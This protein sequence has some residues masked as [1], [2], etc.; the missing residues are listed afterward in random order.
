M[1]TPVGIPF[2]GE[3]W[4]FRA[5]RTRAPLRSL[6]RR[7]KPL[8]SSF[9]TTHGAPMRLERT[10]S[11]IRRSMSGAAAR[12]NL[13]LANTAPL[14]GTGFPGTDSRSIIRGRR[15]RSESLGAV[16]VAPTPAFAQTPRFRMPP[17]A[18]LPKFDEFEIV[19]HA[20]GPRA[21]K[22]ARIAI[23]RFVLAP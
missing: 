9:Q 11:W 20:D 8:E 3:Y 4:M 7:G 1:A 15:S 2:S 13:A 12:F 19:F 22:S 14:P 23:E 18:A 10:I 6:L 17:A 5:S 16:S 21:G